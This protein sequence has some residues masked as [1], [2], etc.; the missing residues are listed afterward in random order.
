MELEELLGDAYKE[1]MTFDEVKAALS[2]KKLADLSSGNYIN[3]EWANKEKED[4]QNSLNQQIED[5]QNQ[6]NGKLT[7]DEKVN[8][9]LQ[10]KDK[11]I[12]KLLNT[13]KQSAIKSNK[14]KIML[15]TA[16]IRGKLGINEDDTDFNSFAD[17]ITVEDDKNSTSISAYLSTLLK[18]AY[19]KGFEQAQK[20]QMGS[21]NSLI[22]GNKNDDADD[23]IGARL[24][25]KNKEAYEKVSNAKSSFFGN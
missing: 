5:L 13:I 15:S 9:Q 22:T 11:E 12:E 17:L 8:Q 19:D 6:L 10:A 2:G 25:K 21:N 24:G 3:K 14:S 16:E 20:E 4:L 7:E 23:N 18:S 1:G